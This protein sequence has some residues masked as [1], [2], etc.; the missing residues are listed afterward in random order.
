MSL[1]DTILAPL[2]RA[3]AAKGYETLTPVQA[4]I[5]ED[6]TSGRDL[7]VSA[8]TGS[9]KTVAFGM[10][11]APTLLGDAE[12]FTETGAPLALLIAPT[13]ELALQ[14]QRELEWLY[15]ETGA[16]TASCVGGMDARTERRALERGAHIV[17][18]TPGRLRDHIT[19]GALD[20]SALRAVVLDEADEMLDLG[21]RE[22][23]EFILDAAPEDRRTLL[24]SATV[25][26]PIAQLAKTFQR[27]AL[28]VAASSG[29]EQHADIDYKLML[30]PSA[31]RENAIINTL[32]YYEA[33][34]TIVFASTREGVKHLSARLHNRGFDVVTLSGE[35]SQSERTN[36]LQSMRDGRA[37]ICVAT[38]VA[39]RGIDL[40]N[41]DLVIHADLPT[42][43]DTLLHRSGRTGRAGRKGTCVI[44][45]PMHRRAVAQRILK[46]ARLDV[47]MMAPPSA[48][49]IEA[50]YRE[51]I[52]TAEGLTQPV[53]EEEAEFVSQ[54][55]SRYTPEAIA[56]AYLRQQLAARPA[57]EDVSDAPVFDKP[58]DKDPRTR[59]KFEGG[60]WFK[61]TVG[62]K[63]KAEP[64]WLLPML[65]KAGGV[66]KTAIGSIRIF[67]TESIF[68]VAAQKA[69]AFAR[70]VEKN[71]SGERGVTIAPVDGPG[72]RRAG[73]PPSQRR[74]PGPVE[75]F[76]PDAPRPGRA[77][78][79]AR[80]GSAG[81]R[82]D[83][84]EAPPA[85]GGW[86]PAEAEAPRAPRPDFDKPR[87]PK[88]NKAPPSKDKGKPK[89]AGKP[90]EGAPFAKKEKPAK[91]DHKPKRKPQV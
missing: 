30:V 34:N 11:I 38:D 8:Q 90:A 15:A 72:E 3:L 85:T 89:W 43:A 12:R 2:A 22:D 75:R 24:F 9:G 57:P 6:Q 76:D 26:K 44:I 14:V 46:T 45:A 39:A 87:P 58:G 31:E 67:D 41:L 27:D 50:R 5:I 35:L 51:S 19:R 49:E 61:V 91:K 13:R 40:P 79:Q 28:R 70:S 73:P 32:L 88:V 82:P 66:T 10:A 16:R 47:T 65:C 48:E 77:D 63:H 80:Y 64:R 54:L 69:D 78:R 23:L 81:L 18:G 59:E 53:G 25:P 60:T 21:F 7:L 71:G 86:N 29:T 62:R 20:M 36:A 84:L 74:P 17:V 83:D 33:V 1:P 68:E 56:A 52:L 37:R 55:L 42:N 4:A